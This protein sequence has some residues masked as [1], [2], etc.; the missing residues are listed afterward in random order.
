MDSFKTNP[1]PNPNPL[2]PKYEMAPYS[3]S[4]LIQV[5]AK[6]PRSQTDLKG[7]HL[8]PF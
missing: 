3:L 6:H 8:H 7:R 1:N 2:K 4:G 5:S